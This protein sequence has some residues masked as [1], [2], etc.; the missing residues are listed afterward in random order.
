MIEESFGFEGCA[1]RYNRYLRTATQVHPA[2]QENAT[3]LIFEPWRREGDHLFISAEI[4]LVDVGKS[5][6]SPP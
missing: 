1:I 3:V 2:Q 4:W 5:V 6:K